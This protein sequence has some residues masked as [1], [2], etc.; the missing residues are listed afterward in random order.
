MVTKEQIE[1]AKMSC[2]WARQS[3]AL[4][5]Q[6]WAMVLQS[7]KT[8][9]NNMRQN[10]FPMPEV[11]KQFEALMQDHEEKCKKALETLENSA[12]LYCDMLED[13]KKKTG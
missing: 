7:Q 6:Y 5:S 2:E 10:G 4:A 11:G 13:L 8:I 1:M 9:V 3:A 12:K